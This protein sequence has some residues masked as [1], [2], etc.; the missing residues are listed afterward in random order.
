MNIKVLVDNTAAQ[1]FE[2]VHGF[3]ALIEAD[4]RI[5]FDVGPTSLF[6]ENAAKMNL[7]LDELK[8]IVLSHGHWD[9]GDGLQFISGKRLITHPNS[10]CLRYRKEAKS[11]V[12]LKLSRE[13]MAAKFSLEEYKS[14]YWISDKM[15]FLGEIPR[16]NDF[17]SQS[18]TFLLADGSPDFVTDDSG[19]AIKTNKGLVVISGC[20]HAG[21]CN[22]VAYA[23]EMCGEEKVYAVLG[24]FHLKKIDEVFQKTVA[25]FQKVKLEL[26]G[27]T[28]CTSFAVQDEFKKYFNTINLEAGVEIEL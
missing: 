17:E 27:A 18:T 4:E 3:S 22:T 25:Y 2:A 12:G 8:T 24:G 6:L 21:I 19:I 16:K 20:A 28:H 15:V 1:G 10:F 9:H 13:E 23:K 7:N 26:L 14:P 5:L 11:I